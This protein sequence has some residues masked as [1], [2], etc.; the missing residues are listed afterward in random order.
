MWLPCWG[1][2]VPQCSTFA[3]PFSASLHGPATN[4]QQ[5]WQ[6]RGPAQALRHG[7]LPRGPPRQHRGGAWTQL[8]GR[9]GVRGVRGVGAGNGE[10]GQHQAHQFLKAAKAAKYQ[11]MAVKS[12][13]TLN[14]IEALKHKR[15]KMES[16]RAF[17]AFTH[18]F[19]TLAS[20]SFLWHVLTQMCYLHCSM[21]YWSHL[22]YYLRVIKHDLKSQVAFC[23]LLLGSR[24]IFDH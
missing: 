9:P 19:V 7:P 13:E 3:I 22:V 18:F 11:N 14:I 21:W 23:D 5:R 10:G 16:T 17:A 15:A 12:F 6:P 4:I 24:E 1:L 2:A 8:Q 20:Q